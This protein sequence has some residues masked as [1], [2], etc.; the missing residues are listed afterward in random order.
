MEIRHGTLCLGNV[1]QIQGIFLPKLRE[2][3]SF[4]GPLL[5]KD[6]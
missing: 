6:Q 4:C 3:P 1:G 2:L 5:K